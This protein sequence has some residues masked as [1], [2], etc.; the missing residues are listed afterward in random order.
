[1]ICFSV[2]KKI[3]IKNISLQIAGNGKEFEISIINAQQL[4][5]KLRISVELVPEPAHTRRVKAVV[6]YD[7]LK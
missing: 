6:I 2:H 1:M 5:E 3:K 7:K 4:A